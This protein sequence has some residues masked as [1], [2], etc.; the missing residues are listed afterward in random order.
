MRAREIR[1]RR[2]PQGLPVEEDFELA[3]VEV[4]APGPGEVRVRN[5][6]LSVD[7]YMRGRMVDRASYIPPFALGRA[8]EGG[9]IGEVVDSGDPAFAPGD[10][11]QSMWGWRE[12]FTA[13]ARSL[14]RLEVPPGVP[15]QA[16]LGVL[17]MPGLTAWAGLLEIGQP[18]PGE[19][20]FVSGGA[21][22]VG[23]LVAQ[24]GKT[25][26][27]HVVATAGS[28][29]KCAWLRE[30]GVDA[31]INYRSCGSL[32]EAVKAAAP[33]G[34]DIYFDNVGG[35]HLE[36]AL[37][38]ANPFARFVE[39]GM[40]AAYNATE[41]PPGPRNLILLIGKSLKMQ[42]FIVTQFQHLAEAFRAEMAARLA[43]GSIRWQETIVG[44]LASAPSAF[45]GLFTGANMGK[46]LIRL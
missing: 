13:P 45:L 38:L 21:G 30:A 33:R 9:A 23:S 40:I 3:E 37:D 17:G 26:G 11:V 31:A 35:E 29:A 34:I 15:P 6:F 41:P 1:L 42:G 28:D 43:D 39:C 16:F 10:M 14:T 27:C 25:R 44:G 12:A 20:L 46:M 7:P 2:R 8:L 19:T 36:V 18:R 32:R 24:L 22:A 4:P 5:R